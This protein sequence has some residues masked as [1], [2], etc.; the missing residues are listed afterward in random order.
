MC[1]L[2]DDRTIAIAVSVLQYQRHHG[3]GA[4]RAYLH[5]DQAPCVRNG[6]DWEDGLLGPLQGQRLGA[7]AALM[8]DMEP[9][10]GQAFTKIPAAL[11][12]AQQALRTGPAA[13]SPARPQSATRGCSR[14]RRKTTSGNGG[15]CCRAW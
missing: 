4:V 3:F 11:R 8:A 2:V 10:R 5:M 13:P 6:P 1:Q 14:H 15:R 12:T 9:Y 7:W